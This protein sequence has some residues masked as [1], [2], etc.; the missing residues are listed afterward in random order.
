ME[1]GANIVLVIILLT[2]L[3]LIIN[4]FYSTGF[5][6][7]DSSVG[8]L[9][10]NVDPGIV[11]IYDT[12]DGSTTGFLYLS[13]IELETIDNMTLERTD[14]GKI[15]FN[16]TVNLTQDVVAG[17][18]NL[19]NNVN[20][21]DN[22]IDINVTTMTS[23]TKAAT[24][25]LY[26]LNFSVARI[27]R[28]GV[29]CSSSFC[30]LISYSNNTGILVF[31]VSQFS[32]NYSAIEGNSAPIF[33]GINASIFVCEASK[34][35]YAFNATDVDADD[36]E[37]DL[38]PKDPFF[39]ANMSFSGQSFIEAEIFSDTLNK[40]HA[41][42]ING[43]LR[44]YSEDITIRDEYGAFDTAYTNI[45]VVEVNNAP[46]I[47]PTGVRTV[48]L[49]GDN[50]T[51]DYQIQVDDVED[52][53]QDSGN[54]FFNISFAGE[55]LFNI[56]SV[57]VMNFTPNSSQLGNY[58][59]TVCVNDTGIDNPYL[60]IVALCGQDGGPLTSCDNFTL[61]VTGENRAPTIT[62][63]TPT[64]L[65]LNVTGAENLDFMITG[66]DPDGTIPDTY[67]YVDDVFQEYD[68]ASSTD[69]FTYAFG[70]GIS[71]NHTIKGEITDGLLNDSVQWNVSVQSVACPDGIDGGGGGGPGGADLCEPKWACYDWELCQSLELSF[72][73][74]DL[75]QKN[76]LSIEETCLLKGFREDKC[77][78]QVRTCFDVSDCNSLVGIPEVFRVCHFTVSPTCYDG[79]RNCHDG[80]CELLVDCG[81]PCAACPVGPTGAS[82]V[83]DLTGQIGFVPFIILVVILIAL[84]VAISYY[85]GKRINRVWEKQTL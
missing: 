71:G 67:W 47:T 50:S 66:Y 30:T 56:S 11:V 43:G 7:D 40:T 48:W 64:N 22:W 14:Y 12:F 85:I 6:I 63:Y 57:G 49:E 54:L 84:L 81:G 27:M 26:G 69:Y 10:V 70:C 75:A 20:I 24:I 44:N 79:I 34:L 78:F 28:D 55:E 72:D 59:I 65:T 25:H 58:N 16:E 33:G 15:I 18:V 82:I 68:A 35:S 17:V 77:G 21:S 53:D 23:L 8:N 62:I 1:K 9:S 74:V 73:K 80:K 39:V 29:V 13:D 76:Y 42:G 2:L 32:N 31:N 37:I 19:D 38:N 46:D 60:D 4:F 3:I 41:G 45:T 83:D 61:A 5:V 36:L 52:G 51:F